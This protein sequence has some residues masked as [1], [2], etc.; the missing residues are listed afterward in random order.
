[1]SFILPFNI[2]FTNFKP[3]TQSA[4]RGDY[5][6]YELHTY[7]HSHAFFNTASC[8]DGAVRMTI[9]FLVKDF[10]TRL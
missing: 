9:S 2:L 8:T 10:K 4:Y 1:M 5:H 3:K 7:L 6:G